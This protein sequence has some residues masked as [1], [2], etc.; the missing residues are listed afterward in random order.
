MALISPGV[1]VTVSDESQYTSTVAS[2]VPY[3]LLATAQDKR[4]PTNSIASG[5]L[6]ANASK[7]YAISTQR[8]LIST[9]GYPTFRQDASGNPIHAHELN[10]YGLLAAYSALGVSNQVLVQRADVDMDQIVGTSTR[11]TGNPSDGIHWLDQSITKLGITEFDSTVGGFASPV[12]N[13]INDATQLSNGKPVSS[14]GRIGEYAVVATN[15]SSPVYYKKYDNTWVLVGTNEWQSARPVIVGAVSYPSSLAIGQKLVL[16]STPVTLTGT[17]VETTAADINSVL[18]AGVTARVN[19]VGQLELYIDSTAT[20]G[21]LVIEPGNTITG[22]VDCAGHLGLFTT[23]EVSA[24]LTLKTLYAPTVQFSDYRD[25]PAWKVTDITPRPSGSVWVKTSAI[26]NG[27]QWAFKRYSSAASGYLSL[28][29]PLYIDDF[30]AINGLDLIGGGGNI[31]TGSLYVKYDVLDNN[32][33]T[34]KAFVKN[35]TGTLKVTGKP[36]VTPYVLVPGHSFDMTVSVPGSIT[37]QSATVG[38]TGTTTTSL[39]ADIMAAGLPNIAAYVESSGAVSISHLA[40]GLIEFSLNN[41]TP[42]STIGLLGLTPA[43][44]IQTIEQGQV[45]LASPWVP[46]SYT[47]ST[48]AP[49]SDPVDGTLWYYNNPLDVDIMVND[50][51]GWKGYK[52]VYTDSRGYDLSLTDELGPILSATK[53]SMQSS[54]GQLAAGDLWIDTS[55]LENYP[56]IRRFDGASSWELIDNTDQISA[57]GIVFADA[58]WGVNKDIDPVVDSLPAITDLQ[59]SNYLD[60][61]APDYRLYARGTLLFNTRR[62]GYNVKRFESTWHSNESQMAAWVS[63]SGIDSNGVPYFGHKAQRNTI[64]EALKAAVESSVHLREEQIDFNL[65]CCP[66]YPELIQNLITL[67]NDRKNTAFIIGDAPMTLKSDS[68]TISEWATNTNF[69]VDN[70]E[71]GLVSSNEYLGVYYPSGYSTD[72]TGNSVVVPPS[73]MMLRTYIRSDNQSYP[74][75]APAGVRRGIIDNASSIGYVDVADNSTFK[76]IGVTVGLRDILYNNNINPLT[77]LPGV[78]LA[79]YGQKT[80]ASMSSSMD[81]VNVSRLV[82]YLRKVLDE[83]ARPFVFEPNDTI[84]R[85]QVKSSFEAVLNDI[86]AKRGIYDYLVV[87]D[88]SNNTSDRIDRNEL[89]I[90]IAIAPVKAIEFIYIPVR[91]KG[92]GTIG[93]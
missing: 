26:G 25:V 28:A 46:L 17:T 54:G 75:F 27:A 55:D 87:C 86:V 72:L 53:P 30:A 77:V 19:I 93:Q 4:T 70:S 35:I 45:Y 56:T 40:G 61:D 5:T 2:T 33:A 50:G 67:N 80:R 22:G 84:T 36:P 43:A 9:F 66:G 13:T 12:V 38:L 60:S 88:T 7:L 31:A 48:T 64:I 24:G 21:K 16:N 58:R 59:I 6:A 23:Q 74:W 68:T 14:Y 51:Q 3:I 79:A 32:T 11:P 63:H 1:Q 78:G 57:D 15:A 90:D 82:C 44:H 49:Y 37:T 42:L 85:S 52:N 73:H 10:E 83:V 41:G 29:A 20:N 89:Y 81:R 39:V 71:A 76:S 62:S 47:Y 92:T 65:I 69:A 8:E 34:F 18:I 91:L